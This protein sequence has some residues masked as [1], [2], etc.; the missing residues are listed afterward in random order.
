MILTTSIRLPDAFVGPVKNLT[1]LGMKL[2]EQVLG[3][4]WTHEGLEK[5]AAHTGQ[6]WKLLDTEFSRPDGLYIPSRS[7]RCVL[8]SAGRILRS[9]AERKR[10][11]ECLLPF[12]TGGAKS[13]AKQLY[14]ELKSAGSPERYGYLLNV[15]EQLANFYA[16]HDRL[17]Q[18][19]FE[20]QRKPE[21]KRFT[22]TLAPD[23]GPEAGQAARWRVEGDHLVGRIKLPVV[24]EPRSGRDWQW[25][26]FAVKLPEVFRE[27][28]SSGGVPCAP[29]LRLK[30]K[31]CGELA[32]LLDVRAEVPE[33]GP[34]GSTGRALAC[35]WGLRKLV[36][37]T[38]VSRQGQVTPPFFLF[39]SGLK[40]KLYRIREQ[41]RKLHEL[42]DRHE[43]GCDVWKA[44][45]RKIAASWQ[46]YHRVQ[47]AL[48]HAVSTLLVLLARAFDCRY[49]FVEWL[50]TLRGRRG[51]DRDLNW[52]VST[53][54][55]GQLFRLLR[56]K[57]RLA[58][59]RVLAVPPGG[60]SR[61]CPRCLSGGRHVVSPGERV[62]KGSGSWFVCPECGWQ[63]DRD[64]AGSL[65]IARAGFDLAR[66]LSYTV[67]GAAQ[68]FPSQAGSSVVAVERA[69]FTTTLGYTRGVF[70]ANTGCLV[71]LL[72]LYSCT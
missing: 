69:A 53:A 34:S 29:D 8:E 30:V 61:V 45:N 22:Y 49:I 12:F 15:A 1:A 32:V 47:R 72:D 26:S 68:P 4:C 67:G 20:F 17:P 14:E 36:T 41:I 33:D 65:N 10:A 71:K 64:Y 19:F 9:Q 59:I 51:R 50:V 52:W 57:A 5:A 62:E 21:P 63:A 31:P 43:K 23:D 16:R 60:T 54:V 46:K 18:D 13:A 37:C 11:Y 2:Q 40:A 27:K 58:G 56:Y 66:P 28:L 35:D 3:C 70:L 7:W 25:L 44:L 38:V 55:R 6:I 48:A 24:P 42:R 39:W